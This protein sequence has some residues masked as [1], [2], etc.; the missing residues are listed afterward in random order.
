M[1]K[2]RGKLGTIADKASRITAQAGNLI[3]KAASSKAVRVAA[4][5]ALAVAADT[6]VAGRRAAKAVAAG[7]TKKTTLRRRP[8]RSSRRPA[9]RSKARR[10]G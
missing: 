8:V 4:G 10:A 6:L 7:K 3:A 2:K 9:K 5:S 1:P